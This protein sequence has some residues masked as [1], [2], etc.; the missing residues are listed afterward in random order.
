MGV[1]I[2]DQFQTLNFF[3][4]KITQDNATTTQKKMTLSKLQFPDNTF[5]LVTNTKK[6]CN[7]DKK[8]VKA[9]KNCYFN[10]HSWCLYRSKARLSVSQILVTMK[11]SLFACNVG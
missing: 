9:T 10:R 1:T 6:N 5:Y 11:K 2:S 3:L 7:G 8:I 4:A